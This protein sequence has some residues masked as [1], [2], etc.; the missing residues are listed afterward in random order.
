MGRVACEPALRV[1]QLIIDVTA[2]CLSF[3][4]L[5]FMKGTLVP[6]APFIYNQR[7]HD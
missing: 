6:V 4:S 1:Q 5:E 2:D 7:Y 3:H